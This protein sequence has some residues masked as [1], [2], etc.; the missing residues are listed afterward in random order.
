MGMVKKLRTYTWLFLILVA[1]ASTGCVPSKTNVAVKSAATLPPTMVS[2][3]IHAQV[4]ATSASADVPDRIFLSVDNRIV[5]YPVSPST[6]Y[7]IGDSSD[8]KSVGFHDFSA[9]LTDG[10]S[11]DATLTPSGAVGEISLLSR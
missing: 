2:G 4:F 8:S 7:S 3:S 10:S 6:R 9:A 5:G 11:V 1:V